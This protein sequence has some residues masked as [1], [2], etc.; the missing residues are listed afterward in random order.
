MIVSLNARGQEKQ[1]SLNE[2]RITIQ[3]T[4]KPFYTVVNR[5]IN[6]YDI[7][8]GFEESTLDR[9]HRHF[10]FEPNLP[11]KLW[12]DK[13]EGGDKEILPPVPKFTEHLITLNFN[14]AS[15]KEVMDSIVKQMNNYDWAIADDVVNIF[16]TRGQDPRLK[17]LLELRVGHFSM[18]KGTDMGSVQAQLMLFLPEMKTFLSENNLEAYAGGIGSTFDER[19]LPDVA[20]FSNLSFKELLNRITKSKR[21]GWILQIKKQDGKPEMEFLEILI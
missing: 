5:L 11:T 21:G 19:V 9:D 20:K 1:V 17:K 14:D 18:D 10:Y 6:K 2:K 13:Y 16:P 7:A 12:R 3:M 4:A 15:L 8:I